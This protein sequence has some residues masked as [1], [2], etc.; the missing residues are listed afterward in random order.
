MPL[1]DAVHGIC[2]PP[3]F[4][5]EAVDGIVALNHATGLRFLH[6]EDVSVGI[7]VSGMQLRYITDADANLHF[8]N[9]IN[10]WAP[11]RLP[12]IKVR[13]S[14]SSCQSNRQIS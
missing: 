2:R 7:W 3:A 6:F 5:Q 13:S 12:E 11:E 4:V 8:A 10:L 14:L 1:H 9:E